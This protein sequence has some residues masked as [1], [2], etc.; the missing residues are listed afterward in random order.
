MSWGNWIHQGPL[1]AITDRYGYT[2]LDGPDSELGIT[3]AAI[4]PT[5]SNT[6]VVTQGASQISLEGICNVTG[7]VVGGGD[8]AFGHG[9]SRP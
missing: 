6:V 9:E 7:I 8:G 5:P 3:V 4:K 1:V 2:V